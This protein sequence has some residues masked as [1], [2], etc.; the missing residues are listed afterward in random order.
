MICLFGNVAKSER[1]LAWTF[2]EVL[3]V[4]VPIVG[5][6]LSYAIG[7]WQATKAHPPPLV[8]PDRAFEP[9][10]DSF[11]QSMGANMTHRKWYESKVFALP[12]SFHYK[13]MVFI[14]RWAPS[15]NYDLQLE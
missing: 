7:Y 2:R 1:H 12:G 13:P 4:V 8:P 14:P 3:F 10:I 5:L 15:E 11:S 9:Q 6:I